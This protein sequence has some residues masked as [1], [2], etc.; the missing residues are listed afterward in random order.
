[1][2]VGSVTVINMFKY[3]KEKS[4]NEWRGNLSREME[5]VKDNQ[6]KILEPKNTTT[7]VK[8]TGW[9]FNWS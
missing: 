9:T 2:L 5:T 8:V 3:S 6:M 7:N 1:M 4:H